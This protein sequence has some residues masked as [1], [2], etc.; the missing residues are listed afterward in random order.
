MEQPIHSVRAIHESRFTPQRALGL[1][2]SLALQA[3]II[4]AL[5]SGLAATL[6]Q[7]LPEELKAEVVREKLPDKIPPP[8]PPELERPPPPVVPPPDIVI[9]ADAPATTSIQTV[10]KAPPQAVSAPASVGPAHSIANCYPAISIRLQEQGIT[11]VSFH[12]ATDGTVKDAQVT[13]SSGFPRL[14]EAAVPCVSR[15]RYRPAMQNGQPVEVPWQSALKWVL[16][17]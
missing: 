13:E 1:A 10:Q 4:Y 5:I 2:A 3:G 12:I 15:W 14:D 6:I 16:R 11:K 17:N 8:P 9:Q 7:K